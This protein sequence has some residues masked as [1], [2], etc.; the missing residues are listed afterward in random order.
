MY[1]NLV[2]YP[3]GLASCALTAIKATQYK[4]WGNRHLAT[5]LALV[6]L[7]KMHPAIKMNHII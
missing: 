6:T 2:Y 1:R 3:L 7:A 4:K 5:S